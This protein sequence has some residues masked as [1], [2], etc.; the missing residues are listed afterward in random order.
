MFK[1]GLTGGI[2]SGKTTVT[3]L[4]T[5]HGV[6][7]IDAD[8]I[9]HQLSQAQQPALTEIRA[10]FGD[11]VIH[12]D[13]SLNRAYLKQVIFTDPAYKKK[14]EAILH[15]LVFAEM[16]NQIAQLHADY[17]ILCIPLLLETGRSQFVDRILLID[18][19]VET[20][21]ER[22]RARDQLSDTTIQAIID[23]QTSRSEKLDAADDIINNSGSKILLADQV[24]K[25]HNSY[26]LLSQTTKGTTH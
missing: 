9:A 26:Y 20:Q 25:L 14:L 12:S 2:G 24:K 3:D 17:V 19:P 18:C 15:P 16:S 21:I 7:I 23:A 1:I 4:F 22:V 10:Q 11:P 5:N 8:I 6:P 13:G